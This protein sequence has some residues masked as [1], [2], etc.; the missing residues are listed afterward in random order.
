MSAGHWQLHFAGSDLKI[1]TRKGRANE[2][3]VDLTDYCP[4]LLPLL[5][6]FLT[7][8]RPR[9]PG[10]ATSPFLFLT[11]TGRPFSAARPPDRT[12][13]RGG[14]ADGAAVLSASDPQHLGHGVP[15]R[16]RRITPRS[17]RC[18]GTR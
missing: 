1:G 5:D 9:L 13:L 6:E 15:R 3:K 8:Y 11:Q 17:P 12:H 2:Y 18:W 16:E 10:A 7:T 14:H 4:E